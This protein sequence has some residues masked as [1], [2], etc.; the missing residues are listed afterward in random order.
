MGRTTCR[1]LK[2]YPA[3]FAILSGKHRLA[4]GVLS[5]QARSRGAG[6]TRMAGAP[7]SEKAVSSTIP[8]ASST[9]C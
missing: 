4:L 2:P 8:L 6:T 7:D 5:I 9:F 1:L 3:S